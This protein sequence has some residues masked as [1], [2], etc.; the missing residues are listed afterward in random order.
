[1]EKNMRYKKGKKIGEREKNRWKR[2][3][4]RTENNET[5]RNE[6]PK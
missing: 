2:K 3:T 5:N 1:M 6:K 4:K